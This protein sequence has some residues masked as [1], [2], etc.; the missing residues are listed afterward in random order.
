MRR[1]LSAYILCG[2]S[3]TW[4]LPKHVAN[5]LKKQ[6]LSKVDILHL[7]I[8]IINFYT[9]APDEAMAKFLYFLD[10]S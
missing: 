1:K 7:Q 2:K 8:F 10:S 4:R 6:A 5:R 3:R 9:K